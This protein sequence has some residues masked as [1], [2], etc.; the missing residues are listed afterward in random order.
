MTNTLGG[1]LPAQTLRPYTKWYNVH[2]RH[3]LSEF[4]V[5]GLILASIAVVLLLHLFGARLN[6]TKAKKWIRAHAAP[7]AV[8]FALVGY[9]GVPSSADKSSAE[10]EKLSEQS[11]KEKSLFEFA[12]YATG[13]ANVAFVDVKLTLKKRFNPLTTFVET[14]LGFFTDSFDQPA[15]IVEATL[16]PF[17][18]KEAL[19]VPGLPGAAE[20]RAKDSKSTFDGF[21]FALVHKESMKKVRD[22]RYD[23]SLTITKDHAKLPSW[24]TVM[25][26]S[27][28]ITELMLTP[29]LIK[30]AEAAGD[31]FEYL[32]V[33]DQPVE[34]PTTIDE[35]A[36]RKRIFLK[37]RLPSDNNYERLVPL[38]HY[39]LRVTD[40][41]VQG[42]HFRPE[43]MRKVK[44]VRDEAVRLIQKASEDEK[45]EERAIERE[46]AKK[47][48]RDAELK[49]L[50]AKA[51]KKYLEKEREKETRKGMKRQTARA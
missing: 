39:F 50:D 26:E 28:E 13:R 33:S 48:K 15:D 37:Y 9:S 38:F 8:E 45:A 18:G 30:T 25:T 16:Y 31:L 47:A 46:K 17:D 7:L 3:S 24:L 44:A 2:E 20:I 11:L 5:E 51:Q 4:K 41:L 27:A 22:D 21:V 42:A 6:R 36:P 1:A 14:A 35:T 40:L 23:V 34:R 32:I 29:E 12:T 10:L 49:S 43:V 19:T